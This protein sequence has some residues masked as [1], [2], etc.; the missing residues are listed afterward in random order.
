MGAGPLQLLLAQVCT[1]LVEEVLAVTRFGLFPRTARPVKE[2]L[3]GAAQHGGLVPVARIPGQAGQAKDGAGH[4]GAVAVPAVDPQ[5]GLK[6]GPGAGGVPFRALHP[7]Q[8]RHHEGL[9]KSD[10]LPRLGGSFRVSPGSGEIPSFSCA[11]PGVVVQHAV[12]GRSGRVKLGGRAIVALV[13][14][15]ATGSADRT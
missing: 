1:G 6:C 13:R 9:R 2:R 11:F 15:G 3:R 10:L 7:A 5:G 12:H 8:V 14:K 4:V